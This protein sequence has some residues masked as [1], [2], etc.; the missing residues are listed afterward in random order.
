MAAQSGRPA[1][2]V[3]QRHRVDVE[4]FDPAIRTDKAQAVRRK[5]QWPWRALRIMQSQ[6]DGR[7]RTTRFDHAVWIINEG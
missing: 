2:P 3:E 5:A 4:A 6:N 1:H 7:G